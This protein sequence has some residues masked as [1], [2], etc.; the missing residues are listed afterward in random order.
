MPIAAKKR[1]IVRLALALAVLVMACSSFFVVSPQRVKADA[2]DNYPWSGAQNVGYS[3]WGYSTCPSNAPQCMD[4]TQVDNGVTYG[5]ADTWGYAFRNCTSWAAWAVHDRDGVDVPR[6]LGN[7][8]TWATNASSDKITV[9]T[10]PAAGA[11]AQWNDAGWNFNF[12]HVAYV[13]EV[14]SSTSITIEQYNGQIDQNNNPTGVWSAVTLTQGSSNPLPWPDNFI[15][16]GSPIG[17]TS[18]PSII[19]LKSAR[20]PDSTAIETY[21]ATESRVTQ[22]W[23]YDGGNSGTTD[24]ID[25]AQNNIVGIDKINQADGTESLYTAVPDGVWESWWNVSSGGVHSSKI[26]YPGL[27]GITLSGVIGVIAENTIESGVVV[28]HLYILAS[29]GPYEAYW[30]DGGDGVHLS[31]LIQINDPI[32]FTHSIGPDGS[33]QL[34]VAVPTWVYEVTWVPGSGVV[35]MYNVINITQADIRSVVKGDNLPGG[36]QLLYTTTS[37]TV[38][39]TYWATTGG[40]YSTGTIATGQT[41][42]KQALKVVTPDGIHH[43]YLALPDHVQEYWWPPAF[44]GGEIIRISQGNIAAI[45]QLLDGSMQLL[46][47]A[48]GNNVWET[49]WNSSQAP[50]TP[51]TP[52]FQVTA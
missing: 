16:F 40:P 33:E 28:H 49:W 51:T 29:D 20:S 11:V 48:A 27:D 43:V 21:A 34:Y 13:E 18:T 7:G 17:V 23:Y 52:L 35:N 25:I 4:L 1:L 26:V 38:W 19:A 9:N 10:T 15:H 37:T 32:A 36:G 45:S 2:G 3:A 5:I 44:G 14:N 41:N 12:G 24:I 42:A 8:D 31:R 50:T 46:L 39:Q 47:T 22:H 6:G 30:K